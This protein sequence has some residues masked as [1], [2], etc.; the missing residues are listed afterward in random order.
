M[1]KTLLVAAFATA[2]SIPAAKAEDISKD[3]VLSPKDPKY[4]SA[5]CRGLR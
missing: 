5:A 1:R 4:N 2:L 3:I